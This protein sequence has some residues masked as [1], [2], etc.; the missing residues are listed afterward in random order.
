MEAPRIVSQLSNIDI[1][2]LHT[3][4]S[5]GGE[6]LETA[7]AL[8]RRE[9]AHRGLLETLQTSSGVVDALEDIEGMVEPQHQDS[10][11]A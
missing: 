4:A 6:E 9:M 2:R 8:L 7:R 3:E 10:T 1:L 5:Q 11:W